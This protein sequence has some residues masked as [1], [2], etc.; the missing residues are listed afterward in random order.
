MIIGVKGF[1]SGAAIVADVDRV[2]AS[3]LDNLFDQVGAET[4][5]EVPVVRHG[6]DQQIGLFAL[7]QRS[8]PVRAADGVG[9][10]D[11]GG[12]DRLG[13]PVVLISHFA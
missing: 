3:T 12:G 6:Q 8:D 7:F 13:R 9:G 5:T 11:G 1:G 2:D 10:V 4:V